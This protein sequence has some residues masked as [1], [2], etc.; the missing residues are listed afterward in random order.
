M[1]TDAA[2][3]SSYQDSDLFIREVFASTSST[4]SSLYTSDKTPTAVG[5]KA[6]QQPWRAVWPA[7]REPASQANIFGF[8]K[9]E[10]MIFDGN[11]GNFFARDAWTIE[12]EVNICSKKPG[13]A[14]LP[15]T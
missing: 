5:R 13:V 1:L 10:V 4:Y 6:K 15:K 8:K 14:H 12:Q 7:P 11:A 9:G 3:P 2:E